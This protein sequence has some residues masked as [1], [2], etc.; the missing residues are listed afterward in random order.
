MKRMYLSLLI[1]FSF[2]LGCSNVN[3]SYDNILGFWGKETNDESGNQKFVLYFTEGEGGL[4]CQFHSYF[5]KVKFSSE[6]GADIDFDGK[7]ISFIA[8]QMANVRYEGEID[9]TGNMI[10]GKLK[11]ADGSEQNFDLSKIS[12]EK[13]ASDYP[14]LLNLEKSRPSIEQPNETEDGW[15]IGS[16][17]ESEIDS[18]LLQKMVEDISN[19]NF[20]KIHSVL[21]SRNGKLVFEKYFDGFFTNDLNSLQSCT[22][23]IGS[24]LIGLAI[25]KGYIKSVDEKILD[26]FPA[27]KVD[28]EKEWDD[29]ELRHLLTMSVGLDWKRDVLDRVY[30]ISDDAIETTFEQIFSHKPGQLFEYRSPQT[31][32]LSG[33]I[34]KS[35]EMS[36]QDF[37]KEYLFDP[38]QITSF[39]WPNFK[40]NNYPLMSGSLALR[41]RDMLKIGQLVL[42]EGQWN[43]KQIVSKKWIEESTS[44]KIKTDQTLN[45]GYLW[46]LGESK[47]KPGLKGVIAIGIGGQHIAI[48][49]EMNLVVVTTANNMSKDPDFLLTMIDDY[50]IKGVK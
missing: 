1:I 6:I 37:A 29:V 13:L 15:K 23:S 50:I 41:S 20:G 48:V 22:K 38:L 9:S 46:W 21:I 33:I 49:P 36:V 16:L 28:V 4:S 27:Y 26:F 11:Y 39:N 3:T 14:G 17:S 2:S 40:K 42:D 35:S 31:D 19:G 45:Y 30:G 8:N 25:N 47:V 12:K 7:S 43:N 18:L 10:I 32:L 44:F 34:I 5:N 24:L